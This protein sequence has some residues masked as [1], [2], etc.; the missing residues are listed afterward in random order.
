MGDAAISETSYE[1]NKEI[2][3]VPVGD[4]ARETFTTSLTAG[5][6]ADERAQQHMVQDS[7]K[8]HGAVEV[9][10]DTK[11]LEANAVVH[12][13]SPLSSDSP[14]AAIPRQAPSV[15]ENLRNLL[16]DPLT[17]ALME[18]A[19][20]A[21]CGHSFGSGGMQ[22][23][24]ATGQCCRCGLPVD[25]V[26]S[27]IPNYTVRAMASALAKDS[28]W[29]LN[30]L[31]RA[32]SA[33]KRRREDWSGSAEPAGGE[34]STWTGGS[35]GTKGRGVQFPFKEHDRVLIKGN[36]RTP[37]R[38]VGKTATVTTLCLN[39]WYLVRTDDNGESVRLQYRSLEKAPE[40]EGAPAP[41]PIDP[42]RP[43]IAPPKRRKPPPKKTDG[44]GPSGTPGS[45]KSFASK[46]G[47]S[48]AT[49][50]G[51]PGSAAATPS[52]QG[53]VKSALGADAIGL[54]PG[55]I[56]HGPGVPTSLA[57][58]HLAMS[59]GGVAAP[60]PFLTALMGG[61]DVWA[62]HGALDHP[63]HAAHHHTSHGGS[64]MDRL[65]GGHGSPVGP[66][67]ASGVG[68]LHAHPLSAGGL[69]GGDPMGA[70]SLG[71]AAS[72][73]GG[74]HEDANSSAATAGALAAPALGFEGGIMTSASNGACGAATSSA[75]GHAQP[76]GE[77]GGGAATQ[78]SGAGG[79]AGGSSRDAQDLGLVQRHQAEVVAAIGKDILELEKAVPWR[80]GG[81]GA[82]SK[83]AAG[84]GGAGG[85][86]VEGEYVG[87]WV[88]ARRDTWRRDVAECGSAEV[89]GNLM[90]ELRTAMF[91]G[92]G[93]HVVVPPA[94]LSDHS[95]GEHLGHHGA[96]GGGSDA[97]GPG[98]RWEAGAR[99]EDPGWERQ[100]AQFVAAGD[101]LGLAVLC[102]QLLQDARVLLH[103]VLVDDR[104]VGAGAGMPHH[105]ASLASAAA[106]VQG[107]LNLGPDQH[108]QKMMGGGGGGLGTSGNGNGESGVASTGAQSNGDGAMAGTISALMG[109]GGKGDLV[110][111][112]LLRVPACIAAAVSTEVDMATLAES[113]GDAHDV[114]ERLAALLK[115]SCEQLGWTHVAGGGGGGPGGGGLLHG[116]G[117]GLA[118]GE[119]GE[120]RGFTVVRNALEKE[121]VKVAAMIA[122]L[123]EKR[124]SAVAAAAAA[125]AAMAAS[126]MAAASSTS[127]TAASSTPAPVSASAPATSSAPPATATTASAA[128]VAAPSAAAVTPPALS[129]TSAPVPGAASSATVPA[130]SYTATPPVP[131]SG[132]GAAPATTGA[133][134]AVSA[135]SAG[136]AAAN[137]GTL[138]SAT[139][140]AAIPRATASLPAA[141]MAPTT[142]SAVTDSSPSG[143]VHGAVHAGALPN[144]ARPH[145]SGS[146]AA[147]PPVTS[148]AAEPGVAQGGEG[149]VGVKR[150]LGAGGAGSG[151]PTG[152]SS[153]GAASLANGR[154][155]ADGSHGAVPASESKDGGA[156]P[157][158]VS[159]ASSQGTSSP[160]ALPSSRPEQ[161]GARGPGQGEGHQRDGGGLADAPAGASDPGG[162]SGGVG[163]S[164]GGGSRDAGGPGGEDVDMVDAVVAGHAG[165]ALVQL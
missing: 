138:P 10:S 159:V 82:I 89:M 154:S 140:A 143:A 117:A 136:P 108:N 104:P 152:G 38:F 44:V 54:I 37:T 9:K 61:D 153:G 95:K 68:V 160:S 142:A 18:D 5:W 157:M 121:R 148:V 146:V 87:G 48:Q 69:G 151:Q 28:S 22:R 112:P 162:S 36:K 74:P 8:A 106:T 26:N 57:D 49:G 14:A 91:G 144:G 132:P 85:V 124:E 16:S 133:S 131:S 84:G 71:V 122:A 70:I 52:G 101:P 107:F 30:S 158:D 32:G 1:A 6:E 164:G 125:A 115:L 113:A 59:L 19:V 33:G 56:P 134:A 60:T 29:E 86:G 23:T 58:D 127:A 78:G 149:H 100:L 130:S 75:G 150:E 155:G 139:S 65:L 156:A 63:L 99:W 73:R 2:A 81:G 27:L 15:E 161:G 11:E 109:E 114:R 103:V 40:G 129:S 34:G 20:I 88:A 111:L 3:A 110:G 118:R 83:S 25:S 42:N 51:Q 62:T 119:Q 4:A 67:A 50:G 55:T 93:R 43:A 126:S 102:L 105:A 31:Q 165:V 72:L 79:L 17:G 141:G 53:G 12:G 39:G 120:D 94:G 76:P 135:P 21:P 45:E 137:S 96:G 41:A 98:S 77:A 35:G 147:A 80:A 7:G 92:G 24:A 47:A 145:D 13:A 64:H 123:R 46:K 116:H 90:A 97:R 66:H 163:L 128:L